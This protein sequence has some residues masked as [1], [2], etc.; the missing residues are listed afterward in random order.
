MTL[1][2]D[3]PLYKVYESTEF[4]DNER[5]EM[6]E[7]SGLAG[8]EECTSSELDLDRWDSAS[9]SQVPLGDIPR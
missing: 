6:L 3:A 9:S 5:L 7:Y 1:Q 4:T 8:M 2:P